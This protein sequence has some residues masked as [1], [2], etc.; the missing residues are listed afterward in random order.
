MDDF[1][2][3]TDSDYTSYWRDWVRDFLS[4][5]VSTRSHGPIYAHKCSS[6]VVASFSHHLFSNTVNISHK[7]KIYIEPFISYNSRCCVI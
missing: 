6:L 7:P 5:R 1:N 4:S 2:S 3:E